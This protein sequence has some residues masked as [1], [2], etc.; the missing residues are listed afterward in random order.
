MEQ[1]HTDHYLMGQA[2]T[3]DWEDI[4]HHVCF[5][6]SPE[7][8]EENWHGEIHSWCVILIVACKDSHYI[9]VEGQNQKSAPHSVSIWLQ[10]DGETLNKPA[11]WR[12]IGF[13]V[14]RATVSMQN[15]KRKKKWS[16]LFLKCII[17][18]LEQQRV[19][20]LLSSTAIIWKLKH[21]LYWISDWLTWI[22]L[23]DLL[24]KLGWLCTD[25]HWT[26]PGNI[27]ILVSEQTNVQLIPSHP[28]L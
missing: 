23:S 7:E 12:H 2:D 24:I 14:N 16:P 28:H 21:E 9:Q 22:T 25:K 1:D 5:Q 20:L 19:M 18:A 27:N 26:S 4:R 11:L 8:R 17:T 6:Q 3:E 13:L 15:W 10:N